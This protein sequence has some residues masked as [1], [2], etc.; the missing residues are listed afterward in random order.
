[1]ARETYTSEFLE[2][3]SL[4]SKEVKEKFGVTVWFAE[5]LGKRWSYIAGEKSDDIFMPPERIKLSERLGAVVE[6]DEISDEELEEIV[7]FLREKVK[8]LG[9]EL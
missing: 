5:I 6:F 8:S 4:I 9:V 7:K 3:L 2:K 1:M